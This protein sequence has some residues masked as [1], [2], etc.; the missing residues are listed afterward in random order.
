[1]EIVMPF[2]NQ[3]WLGGKNVAL[4]SQIG[5]VGLF[6]DIHSIPGPI[7][8]LLYWARGHI[9]HKLLVLETCFL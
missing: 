4:S 5:V 7:T 8:L 6:K 9:L 1:M 3:M 2:G